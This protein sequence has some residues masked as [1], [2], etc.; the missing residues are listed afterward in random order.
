MNAIM[1]AYEY[2]PK[3]ISNFDKITSNIL[4]CVSNLICEGDMI[5]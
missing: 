4:T 2:E 1:Y 5:R 3:D